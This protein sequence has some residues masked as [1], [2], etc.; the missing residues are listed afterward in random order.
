[1]RYMI[2]TSLLMIGPGLGR[3]LIIFGGIPFPLNKI[4]AFIAR[5]NVL[6]ASYKHGMG[7]HSDEEIIEIGN[8]DLKALS[9]FLGDKAYSFGDKPTTLDAVAYGILVE[10]IRVPIFTAPIF[11]QAKS[12]GNLVRFTES[13]HANYFRD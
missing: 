3:A 2:A 10:L 4:I 8:R 13:F 12:Y 7:R 11:D 5:K 6:N 1:M 9:D